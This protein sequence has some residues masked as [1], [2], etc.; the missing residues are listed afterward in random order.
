MAPADQLAGM[1]VAIHVIEQP[2]AALGAVDQPEQC[3]Q[4]LRP[5]GQQGQPIAV[6]VA[7]AGRFGNGAASAISP[8]WGVRGAAGK[9]GVNARFH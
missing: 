7:T 2:D 4:P 9:A 5:F 8:V 6:D 3:V 1:V